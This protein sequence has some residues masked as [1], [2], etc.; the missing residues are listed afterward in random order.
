MAFITVQMRSVTSIRTATPRIA[1][2]GDDT[3]WRG[4]EILQSGVLIGSKYDQTSVEVYSGQKTSGGDG[5]LGFSLE[6]VTFSPDK[7]LTIRW[8][9]LNECHGSLT[10]VRDR[11]RSTA[12]DFQL[13]PSVERFD[14]IHTKTKAASASK[15]RKKDPGALGRLIKFFAVNCDGP[16]AYNSVEIV[17]PSQLQHDQRIDLSATCQAMTEDSLYVVEAVAICRRT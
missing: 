4:I 6:N 1:G 16:V 8:L 9:V 13:A 10:A 14:P 15:D 17:E 5:P 3:I 2:M 12:R 7:P 11:L